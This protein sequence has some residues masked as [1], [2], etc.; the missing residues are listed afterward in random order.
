M[1]NS[2]RETR[3]HTSQVDDPI[4][5]QP[6]TLPVIPGHQQEYL[7]TSRNMLSSLQDPSSICLKELFR[8]RSRSSNVGHHI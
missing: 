5:K 2:A 4:T 6:R 8:C 1:Y 7:M 3:E